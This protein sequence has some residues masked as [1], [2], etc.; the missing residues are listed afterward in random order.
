MYDEDNAPLATYD[1]AMREYALNV[2]ADRP[3]SAWICT[4]FDVWMPNPYYT[5][6]PQPHPEDGPRREDW[7]V[8]IDD[9]E[10]VAAEWPESLVW[11]DEDLPF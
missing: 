2:G 9:C 8:V 3:D 1:D 11:D 5:G 10:P 4:P 6:A 7:D